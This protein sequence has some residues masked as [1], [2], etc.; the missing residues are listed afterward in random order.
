[1]TYCDNESMKI[2]RYSRDVIC[3][4]LPNM[5]SSNKATQML[6]L[7]D[8]GEAFSDYI[9]CYNT[10]LSNLFGI[11][12]LCRRRATRG[13]IWGICPPEIFKTLHSNFD[14][15]RNFQRIKMKFYI[16]IIFKKSCWSF[17]LS[18]W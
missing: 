15:C 6:N 7:S 3:E 17:S 18:Y 12:I 8:M 13:G 9:F 10:M 14:I 16:L 4:N 1:M 2:L 11:G 5:C